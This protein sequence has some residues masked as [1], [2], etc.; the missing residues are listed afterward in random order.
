MAQ[1]AKLLGVLLA[2]STISD[3]FN[4]LY[5]GIN[6]GDHETDAFSL[7]DREE[8]ERPM[9]SQNTRL[10]FPTSLPALFRKAIAAMNYGTYRYPGGTTANYWDWKEGCETG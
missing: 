5:I 8:R 9:I 7:T 2:T 1:V 4:P 10:F 3:A 6:N